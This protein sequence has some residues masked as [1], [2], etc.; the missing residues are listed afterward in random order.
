MIKTYYVN[1]KDEIKETNSPKDISEDKKWIWVDLNEPT[2]EESEILVDYF[3]FHP[4]S[5]E[6]ATQVQQRP[7]FKQYDDYQFIVFHALDL[8]TLESEEVDIFIGDDFI[9]TF[10]RERY[11]EIDTIKRKLFNETIEINEPK[12]ILLNILDDIVD[13]Y[14]PF[15]YDIEDK[16]FNFEDRH[17][18]DI[19]TKTLI[20]DTF[21]LRQELLIIK[22]TV[23]PMKDLVYRMREGKVLHLNEQQFLY[24]THINDHLMKQMEMVDSSRE[25][26]SDIRDNYISLNSFKMNNIMKILTIYSVVFM[27]LTLIAG[28]YGMNFTNMPELEW[29]SGYYIVLII[30]AVIAIIMLIVFK[31][32]RWF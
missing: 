5:V 27:P 19:T 21:D 16:V 29:H 23:Q 31:K 17:N 20:D 28:I 2:K 18:L 13:N 10:H 24:I 11:E 30:M 9:V 4:L 8:K 12:D 22:R 14:F 3:D 25:M 26:T 32:K 1:L 15:I 6:D 7:K